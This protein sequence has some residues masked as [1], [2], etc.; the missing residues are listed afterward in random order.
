[1]NVLLRYFVGTAT[2]AVCAAVLASP[3]N[4]TCSE[5]KSTNADNIS[6]V[7]VDRTQSRDQVL[8][9]GVLSVATKDAK[10]G[11]RLLMWSVGGTVRPLPS[12]VADVTLPRL[13]DRKDNLASLIYKLSQPDGAIDAIELC[14]RNYVA[15]LSDEYLKK[16]ET[17]A[18]YRRWHQRRKRNFTNSRSD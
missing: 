8:N 12:L 1:M 13:V 15:A 11:T 6:I 14:A 2:T 16:A 17:R 7:I 5:P 9:E 3:S 10:P 4:N 18:C